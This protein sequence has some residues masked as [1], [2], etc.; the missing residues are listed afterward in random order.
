MPQPNQL[1]LDTGDEFP[2]LELNLIGGGTV[3]LPVEEWTLF[4]IYRGNW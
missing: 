1:K 4:L 3:Q 2:P